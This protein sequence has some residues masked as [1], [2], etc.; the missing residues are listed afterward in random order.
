MIDVN[1]QYDALVGARLLDFFGTR[2]PWHRGLWTIG[3]V[4]TLKELLEVSSAVRSSILYQNSVEDLSRA[5][6]ALAGRDPG[7]GGKQRQDSL[8][9]S[10]RT[11]LRFQGMDYRVVEQ[12]LAEIDSQY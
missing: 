2:T 12:I 8:Q 6:M 10:L 5:A 9:R 3:L 1:D 7:I 4:L 11:E